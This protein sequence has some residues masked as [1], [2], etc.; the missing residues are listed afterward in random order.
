M[1]AAIRL[2]LQDSRGAGR[3]S[4]QASKS[5]EEM[6]AREFVNA[7]ILTPFALSDYAQGVWSLRVQYPVGA[8]IIIKSRAT[9]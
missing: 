1:G 9:R 5:V 7:T 8:P 3:T 4:A 2:N 6:L